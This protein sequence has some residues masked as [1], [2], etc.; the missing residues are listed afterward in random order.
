MTSAALAASKIAVY[1]THGD[2]EFSSSKPSRLRCGG[3]TMLSV[4]RPVVLF[5]HWLSTTTTSHR[6]S[7]GLSDT[8][9]VFYCLLCR[10]VGGILLPPVQTG[11]YGGESMLSVCRPPLLLTGST[12]TTSHRRSS[13]LSDTQGVFYC[14]LC[15]PVGTVV[16]LCCPS[17]DHHYFSQAFVRAF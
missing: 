16:N 15:R 9:G 6:R 13:G 5:L 10:P 7:S 17:V 1:T 8:H 14:L 11:R 4:C 12:T 3:E 2:R